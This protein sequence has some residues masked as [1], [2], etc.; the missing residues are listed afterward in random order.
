MDPK[1]GILSSVLWT[2]GASSLPRVVAKSKAGQGASLPSIAHTVCHLYLSRLKDVHARRE[3]VQGKLEYEAL[4]GAEA[5]H[6]AYPM[7]T[8]DPSVHVSWTCAQG[9]L[10]HRGDDR[11]QHDICFRPEWA[12][13]PA[14]ADLQRDI[15]EHSTAGSS[16]VR[17]PA[18][19]KPSLA[20]SVEVGGRHE[21]F[22][23]GRIRRCK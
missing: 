14:A 11:E 19:A 23:T 4:V 2:I 1:Q 7:V 5:R 12:A 18:G 16:I 6:F 9:W 17:H 3:I 22:T 8:R 21:C 10:P 13:G 15:P 20:R